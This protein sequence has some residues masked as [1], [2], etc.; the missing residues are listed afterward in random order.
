MTGGPAIARG[1]KTATDSRRRLDGQPPT[2]P[3][4]ARA[5]RETAAQRP[6]AT[7]PQTATS[8]AGAMVI[9]RTAT[10]RHHGIPILAAVARATP[11]VRYRHAEAAIE[12]ATAMAT[13]RLARPTAVEDSP[14][15]GVVVADARTTATPTT[16][17]I[18]GVPPT[19]GVAVS[20]VPAPPT[21]LGGAVKGPGAV[22]GLGAVKGPGVERRPAGMAAVRLPMPVG[23][24]RRWM[25][26]AP[27][28]GEPPA[29]T[30]EASE[31]SPSERAR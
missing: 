22:R 7:T 21:S 16:R 9:Q 15:T 19:T 10:A 5:N 6:A 20:T 14:A 28:T 4:M 17:A 29:M 13:V 18:A 23:V 24:R 11:E 2:N 27:G 25:I 31:R 1:A 26:R 12:P 3:V 30:Q 8:T